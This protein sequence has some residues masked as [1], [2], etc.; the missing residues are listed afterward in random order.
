M[1]FKIVRKNIDIFS[2]LATSFLPKRNKALKDFLK[3]HMRWDE[4]QKYISHLART[5]DTNKDGKFNY[6]GT[7]LTFSLLCAGSN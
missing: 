5:Y 4:A 7:F 6:P 3:D 2:T 1:H